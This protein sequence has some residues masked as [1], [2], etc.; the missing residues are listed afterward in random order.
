MIKRLA[1]F[2]TLN[3]QR[4]HG[5]GL[6]LAGV[7]LG[8][9]AQLTLYLS[10]D[11]P[12]FW[13]V[14]NWWQ[15]F[16]NNSSP[17]PGLL[18]YVLAGSVF[19]YGLHRLGDHPESFMVADT[20]LQPKSPR[21]EFWFTC[22]GLAGLT[23]IYAADPAANSYGPALAI[24]WLLSNTLL[25]ISL[26]R[27]ERWQFPSIEKAVEWLSAHRL[28]LLIIST[29]VLAA[30]FIRFWDVEVHPYSFIND[31]GEKGSTAAC[32][33]N[34]SCSNVFDSGWAAQPILGFLPTSLSIWFLGRTA[35]AVRLA[36]VITGTLAV[37][38]V[39]LFSREAFNRKT[40][41]IAALLLTT[42]PFNVHFSRIGVDN[43]A[44]SL[45][46]T[47]V[48]WLVF[49]GVKRGSTISFM[50]AGIVAGLFFY[51]YPGSRLASVLG[52]AVLG[53]FTL[54]ARGFLKT[55]FKNILIYILAFVIMSAPILGYFFTHLDFFSARMNST[56]IFQ[57][58]ELTNEIHNTGKGAAEFLV[59]QF[60]KSS[61]V[62]I[63]TAAPS[64]FYNSPKPYLTPLAAIF[65]MLGLTYTLWHIKDARF[66]ALLAWFWAAIILGS[67][68]TGGPPT[69]QR[70]LMSSSAL[71]IIV[72]LGITKTAENTWPGSNF[73]RWFTPMCL[74]AFVLFVGYQNINF[75]FGEYR[76]EHYFEDP[77][78]ELTYETR[79]FISPL[80]DTGRFYLICD[81]SI[82]YL[83][84]A[85]FNFFS[86]DVEKAY[87]YEVTPQALA[88]LPK[89]KDAL[90]IATPDRKTEI[91]KISQLI[92]EG[93][94][95]EVKRRTQPT[96]I[97]F[98]SYKIKQ[99][100]LQTFKP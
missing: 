3:R 18:L 13:D 55:H 90:F 71:V 10:L 65:F 89:D 23:A 88:A 31:E 2:Q 80:H 74:L 43:I 84:F 27:E 77:T 91:E 40:A 4:I 14:G 6:L 30:F 5:V 16:G 56:G 22:L 72:A 45:S 26:L 70:M 12:R 25:I 78:N 34:G 76:S 64:N 15:S 93:E 73:N 66:M 79:T 68:I 58:G 36:S 39:Y 37:L 53:Y 24:T 82:P 7:A 95:N 8:A 57:T 61:L 32:I 48:M 59:G 20:E 63:A 49:R 67:T 44:D 50:A 47:L 19:I 46:T 21:F 75:Y 38:G 28:E 42:L 60:M 29:I 99:S 17:L 81:P 41:L 87:L 11:Q 94:W 35:L 97:L 62:Y 85:S 1:E 96:K 69:T 86:P 54:S 98:Y 52:L 100:S 33:L 9:V 51:T 92:P 83:S